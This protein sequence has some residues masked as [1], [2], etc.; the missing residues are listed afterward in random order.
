MGGP[1]RRGVL[2]VDDPGAYGRD[3]RLHQG[4]PERTRLKMAS[5]S[6]ARSTASTSFTMNVCDRRGQLRTT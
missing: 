4:S 1:R 3:L 6:P 2:E 5:S